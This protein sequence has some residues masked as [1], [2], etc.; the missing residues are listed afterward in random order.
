ML[1]LKNLNL[2]SSPT[3]GAAGI[4]AKTNHEDLGNDTGTETGTEGSYYSDSDE[5]YLVAINDPFLH[6][7]LLTTQRSYVDY[8]DSESESEPS[9]PPPVQRLNGAPHLP[10]IASE[11]QIHVNPPSRVCLSRL[12]T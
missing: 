9:P 6:K 12:P 10:R 1:Q 11:P 5:V 8:T 7:Y 3:S 4:L 2:A